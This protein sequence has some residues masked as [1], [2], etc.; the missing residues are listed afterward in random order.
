MFS[1]SL[2]KKNTHVQTDSFSTLFHFVDIPSIGLRYHN[3]KPVI[4]KQLILN[5]I[6][7]P[8]T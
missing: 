5:E 7:C 6:I 3:Q 1:I 2:I 8:K 4:L